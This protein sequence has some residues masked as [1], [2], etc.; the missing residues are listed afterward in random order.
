M[1]HYIPAFY[2]E[3]GHGITHLVQDK[4]WIAV[5]V[6][7]G[8]ERGLIC[9]GILLFAMVPSIPEDLAIELKRRRFLLSMDQKKTG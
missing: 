3:D 2:V 6:I 5:F 8:L 1:M 7:F 4:G 9:F